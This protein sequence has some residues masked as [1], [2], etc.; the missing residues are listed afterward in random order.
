[1]ILGLLDYDAAPTP[2]NLRENVR[3]GQT[4]A[5]EDLEK[6]SRRGDGPIDVSHVLK[7]SQHW[8]LVQFWNR[9]TQIDLVVPAGNP[10]AP[11]NSVGIAA[12]PSALASEKYA[13]E[14]V[15]L[16]VN[17]RCHGVT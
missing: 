3:K 12:L 2:E 6:K 15:N 16:N 9:L 13:S 11:A 7:R 8:P 1:M 10:L 17:Q 5:E 14:A 4:G